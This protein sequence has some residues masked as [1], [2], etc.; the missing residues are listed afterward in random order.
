VL[1][2]PASD[3]DHGLAAS[4]VASRTTGGSP[5]TPEPVGTDYAAWA[6][7]YNLAGGPGNDD[8]LDGI[9]NFLEFLYGSRPDLASDA[10]GPRIEVENLEIDGVSESYLVLTYQQNLNALGALTVEIS[11]DLVTWSSDPGL[12][13]ILTQVDNGDGTVTVSLRLASPV[14]SSGE[15]Y[16]ARLRGN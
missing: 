11:S 12:T 6:V 15:S 8:D 13:E 7:G 2:N 5:G 10:P 4:W 9:S 3:P 16:F 14:N 1:V